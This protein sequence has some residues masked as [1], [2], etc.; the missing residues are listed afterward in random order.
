MQLKRHAADADLAAHEAY[1]PEKKP[2][3]HRKIAVVGSSIVISVAPAIGPTISGIIL[4]LLDW[5]WMFWLVLP[6]GLGALAL[7]YAR[8]Q[9]V[10][11][12]RK[13]PL[14][15]LSVPLSVLAFGGLV[16]GLS[17][18]GKGHGSGGAI[19]V[20]LPLAASSVATVS[21]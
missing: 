10:T 16:Y 12:P 6:I 7:G 9:N 20:W 8:L 2:A 5:R 19:P 3:K 4:N 15:L 1:V 13:T 18:L 11:E 14:D 17:T 21:C